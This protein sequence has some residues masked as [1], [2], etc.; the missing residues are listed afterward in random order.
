VTKAAKNGLYSF[1]SKKPMPSKQFIPANKENP[2]RE[3]GVV[4]LNRN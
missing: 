3:E 1:F 2:K 4:T